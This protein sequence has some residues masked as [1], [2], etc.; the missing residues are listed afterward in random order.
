M[1]VTSLLWK[2]ASPYDAY[3]SHVARL[4]EA[5]SRVR[6]SSER[7]LGYEA[8][9]QSSVRFVPGQGDPI[10]TLLQAEHRG[11]LQ[12]GEAVAL[13]VRALGQTGSDEPGRTVDPAALE[14]AVLD[15]GRPR[16]AFKRLGAA[17]LQRLLTGID[18][19]ADAPG[20]DAAQPNPARN[21]QR[22]RTGR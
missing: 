1:A 17:Q 8:G 16:R 3:V 10:A 20:Q 7:A 4:N 21:A 22:V 11:D 2:L 6:Y 14:A 12:L 15:R 18:I 19:T 13:A 9:L 5:F